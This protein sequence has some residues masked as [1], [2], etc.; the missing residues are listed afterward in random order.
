MWFPKQQRLDIYT[1]GRYIPPMN[2][3]FSDTDG[4]TLK[5]ADDKYIPALTD[6]NCNNYFDPNTGHLYL[7]VSGP[8]TCD[9]KTQPV[10]VLKMGITVDEAEFFNPDTIVANIAGLLGIPASNIRVTNIVREGSNRRRREAGETLDLQ[11]EI[12]EP[13]TEE[14]DEGEF[15]PEEVTYTT[16]LDPNAPTLAPGY[17]TTTTTTPRPAP[18]TVD[19]NKLTFD[20]LSEIQAN[21]AT[22]FQ[23][24]G[25]SAALNVTVSELKMEDPIPPP[26]EPPAYTSPEE[27]AQVL[28]TTYAE[29]VAQQEAE[30]LVQLTEEKSYDVPKNLVLG[31]QPY[32][33]LEM[34]PIQF[35]PY[36][37]FT[38][39]NNEQLSLVGDVADPWRVKATLKAGPDGATAQGSLTVD[40]IGGFANFSQLLLSDEGS[41]YQLTFSLE[42]P[43]T[44]TIPEVDSILFDVGP[45]PLGVK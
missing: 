29:Q 15:V 18:T 25:I 11:F 43:T 8:A 40:V 23:S 35:Y 41:G 10:V 3:D 21:I 31:R 16:P 7:I 36:L 45:R 28:E 26:E 39:E 4:H 32:E 33:A 14:L 34:T 6:T 30:K 22:V 37:Y 9:I 5:P 27:R 12:A 20:K 44:L 13:P 42:Y 2:K 38:N 24:G 1:E 19:P 17:V